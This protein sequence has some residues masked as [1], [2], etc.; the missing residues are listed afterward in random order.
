MKGEGYSGKSAVDIVALRKTILTVSEI[1]ASGYVEEIYLNP[2]CLYT[3]GS[4]DS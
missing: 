3:Q 4:I 1:I 2:G